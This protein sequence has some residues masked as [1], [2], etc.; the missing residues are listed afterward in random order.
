[1]FGKVKKWLGIEGVKLELLLPEK[2]RESD[3]IVKGKI[4]FYSMHS[5]TVTSI[6]VNIV[7][8]YTRGR[9]S[10]KKSDEYQMGEIKLKRDIPIPADETVE[11]EFSL[12]FEMI[13]SD[14]DE[15]GDENILLGGLAKAAKMIQGASSEFRVEAE[16]TVRGTALNPFDKETIEIV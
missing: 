16:A 11:I 8:R 12:P 14:M 9:R 15:L 6:K 1:M 10:E 13:K 7:E 5:Q 3:G 2:V 4:L